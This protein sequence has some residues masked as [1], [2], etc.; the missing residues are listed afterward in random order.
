MSAKGKALYFVAAVAVVYGVVGASAWWSDSRAGAEPVAGAPV[1]PA[2]IERGEYL[3]RLGDC[4][5]CHSIPGEPAFSGG[6]SM[7]T[8]IGAIYSTNITPDKTYGIGSFSLADFD[9]ALRF[10]VSRGHTLYPAM[11]FPS[12][13]NTTPADVEALYAYFLHSVTPA[14]VQNRK[15][16]IPFPFSMRWPLTYW[17]W[18]FAPAPKP[19]EGGGEATTPVARGQYFVEGLGHC[20]ECHTPRNLAMKVKAQTARDGEAFLAGAVIDGWLAP[21]LRRGGPDSLNAWSEAEIE[22]FLKTGTN[23]TGIAFGSMSDVIVHSTQF[24]KPEDLSATS[25]FLKTLQAGGAGRE[26]S[27]AYDENTDRLLRAGDATAR[28]AVLYLDNC[29]TCHR[30]DGHGYEGVFPSLAGNPVVQG[31]DPTSLISIVMRG[32]ETPKT[33]GAPA[34]FTMPAFAWR[35]SDAEIADVLSFVRSSWGNQALAIEARDVTGHRELTSSSR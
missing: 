17:R 29:A 14:A 24:M 33:S 16:D 3:A 25:A 26:E 21:S 32:S 7:S 12:Y 18:A 1:T 35:L 8:P 6:L 15:E 9:R 10:G 13:A 4:A 11:P 27:F 31:K 5:A 22:A 34:Q 28:G 19:F 30:P 20:G 2:L 23:R